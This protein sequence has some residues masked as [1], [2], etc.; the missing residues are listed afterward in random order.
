[1]SVLAWTARAL[2]WHKLRGDE[3]AWR[4]LAYA[5]G[6]LIVLRWFNTDALA[7]VRLHFLG[8]TVATLMFGPRFAL[9]VMAAASLVAAAMGSAWYGWGADF[10]VTGLVPVMVTVLFGRAAE[11]W[12]PANLLLYVWVR[13][14]LGGA[15]AIAAS[16]LLKAGVDWRLGGSAYAA[17]LAATPPMMFAEGF[18]CGGAMALIVIYRPHWCASFD[19]ARYLA[20]PPPS[21]P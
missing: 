20:P 19:D 1:M 13:A 3:E 18:F 2:P 15:I 4:V 14:F 6:A 12:L 16:D 7:G 10:L 21:Q 9:W 5:V 17:Y 8:A 11:R